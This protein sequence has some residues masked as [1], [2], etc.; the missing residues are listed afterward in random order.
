MTGDYERIVNG[1]MYKSRNDTGE[2]QRSQDG[3]SGNRRR[4]EQG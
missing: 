4:F 1:E 2:G 3:S